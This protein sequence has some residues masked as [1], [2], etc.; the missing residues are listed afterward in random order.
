MSEPTPTADLSPTINSN[1]ENNSQPMPSHKPRRLARSVINPTTAS[2]KAI[3]RRNSAE[4][5]LL[6]LPYEIRTRIWKLVLG[7]RL[8]HVRL[9]APRGVNGFVASG[10]TRRTGNWCRSRKSTAEDEVLRGSEC[11]CP[12][13]ER[14]LFTRY[15]KVLRVLGEVEAEEEKKWRE[16][17]PEA[18][19]GNMSHISLNLDF[20]TLENPDVLE[21]F[22]FD[23]FLDGNGQQLLDPIDDGVTGTDDIISTCA[24]H[25]QFFALEDGAPAARQTG[26]LKSLLRE[27]PHALCK[28]IF[29]G[30]THE[31]LPQPA[32]YLLRSCRQIY[33][34]ANAIFWSTNTFSFSWPTD[35][36]HFVQF[37]SRSSKGLITN[38]HLD[39]RS[40]AVLRRWHEAFRVNEVM[41]SLRSLKFLHLYFDKH[42]LC[43][44]FS[45]IHE[46]LM[47]QLADTFA[48]LR[49]LGLRDVTVVIV[50]TGLRLI[51]CWPTD[52]YVR[53]VER[54]R[55]VLM[56]DANTVETEDVSLEYMD[57]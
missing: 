37:H 41:S 23:S 56:G 10:G 8:M 28:Q 46:D 40:R 54:L 19:L 27:H 3:F 7:E 20:S 9:E 45:G 52:D 1:R 36:T 5:P 18:G 24:C 30:M 29:R 17:E 39:I 22:D 38:L 50:W 4:S 32:L 25:S 47:A 2:E 44:N 48:P 13:T 12:V 33:G 43:C 21:N 14:E 26:T 49:A 31:P 16:A 34:E 57:P 53:I 42:F 11:A 55:S 6:R 51:E 15:M 35:L